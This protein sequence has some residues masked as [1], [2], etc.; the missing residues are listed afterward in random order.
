MTSKLKMFLVIYPTHGDHKNKLNGWWQS[1]DLNYVVFVFYFTTTILLLF[2]Q[3][4]RQVGQKSGLAGGGV[5]GTGGG[6]MMASAKP[7][8]SFPFCKMMALV[9]WLSFLKD[10]LLG[11]CNPKNQS[12]GG[13]CLSSISSLLCLSLIFLCFSL[14][15]RKR[16]IW[17]K[18]GLSS[19]R[20]EPKLK[21]FPEVSSHV[22][23]GHCKSKV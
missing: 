18:F 10:M 22:E 21:Y 17:R 20:L 16:P 3:L 5:G 11:R 7:S 6:A 4:T 1:G 12:Q 14:K 8:L 13:Q 15:K 19:V 23:R 9:V 2:V